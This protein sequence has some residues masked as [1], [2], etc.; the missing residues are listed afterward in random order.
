MEQDAHAFRVI[1][2]NLVFIIVF[3]VMLLLYII[4]LCYEIYI[5]SQKKTIPFVSVCP[6]YWTHS[7]DTDNK[8]LCNSILIKDKKKNYDKG[9]GGEIN[10]C[11]RIDDFNEWGNT[12]NLSNVLKHKCVW[13]KDNKISWDSIES[14]GLC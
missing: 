4:Y 10:G 12:D 11:I 8:S 3:T 13:A 2:N 1:K 14:T 5:D 6:D 9:C 7:Y